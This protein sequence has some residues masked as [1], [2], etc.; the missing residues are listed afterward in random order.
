[1]SENFFRVLIVVVLFAHASFSNAHNK[2]VVVPLGGDEKV[3]QFRIVATKDP[4]VAGQG[5][6]EYTDDDKPDGQS[7]WGKVCEDCFEGENVCPTNP[8]PSTDKAAQLVCKDLGFATGVVDTADTSANDGVDFFSLDD[9]S[10][11]DGATSIDDCTSG[12]GHNCFAGLE[13]YIQCLTSVPEIVYPGFTWSCSG[14]TGVFPSFP[15]QFNDLDDSDIRNP[16]IIAAPFGDGEFRQG[17]DEFPSS[18]SAFIRDFPSGN[19]EFVYE[20]H[21]PSPEGSPECPD[22]LTVDSDSWSFEVSSETG[23]IWTVTGSYNATVSEV[24]FE[25]LVFRLKQ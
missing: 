16:V 20:S 7:L 23:R 1:M 13:V 4:V 11:A 18:F 6:L 14:L 9:F 15:D 24:T 22:P 17:F 8:A 10:C 2:V 5:R 21:R 19:L 25:D 3:S 12:T